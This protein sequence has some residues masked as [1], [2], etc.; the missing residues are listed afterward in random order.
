MPQIKFSHRYPKLHQQTSGEL[1]AVKLARSDKI[2]E[3]MRNYDCYWCEN[4]NEGMYCLPNGILI[5]LYFIGNYGIPFSTIR[6]GTARNQIKYEKLIGQMF[7]V[8]FV[9][10]PEA[11]VVQERLL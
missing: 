8:V 6:K 11:E 4:D 1:I 9:D 2:T 5:I 3:R 7:D 10:E